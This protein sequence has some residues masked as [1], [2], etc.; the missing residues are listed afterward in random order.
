MVPD[1]ICASCPWKILMVK[2]CPQPFLFQT[3]TPTR[4]VGNG[5]LKKK[6]NH[7]SYYDLD[8]T[9]YSDSPILP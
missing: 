3:S 5:L 8:E 9:C 1:F 2:K 7:P 4:M 6:K